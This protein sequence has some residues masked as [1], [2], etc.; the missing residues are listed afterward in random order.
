MPGG[1]S[2]TVAPNDAT[3]TAAWGQPGSAANPQ[4]LN[5]YSYVL[6]N[7]TKTTDP[8]GHGCGSSEENAANQLGIREAGVLQKVPRWLKR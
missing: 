6:N 8:T 5:R 4:Q 1:G 7:P 3:A 2:L